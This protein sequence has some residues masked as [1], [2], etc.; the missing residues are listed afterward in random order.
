MDI[1]DL[2]YKDASIINILE[3]EYGLWRLRKIPASLMEQNTT[4]LNLSFF[5][6]IIKS[7]LQIQFNYQLIFKAYGYLVGVF[8]FDEKRQN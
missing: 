3:N 2:D 7:H 5:N 6:P 4:M 8:Q 1:W